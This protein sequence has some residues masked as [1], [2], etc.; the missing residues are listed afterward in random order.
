MRLL[1]WLLFLL[2][3]GGPRLYLWSVLICWSLLMNRVSMFFVFL[4][5]INLL[6]CGVFCL[7]GSRM[8]C[9]YMICF[10]GRFWNIFI[11]VLWFTLYM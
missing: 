10:C 11:D 6:F 7:I 5:W 2:M 9:I 8:W 3:V 4:N 1:L